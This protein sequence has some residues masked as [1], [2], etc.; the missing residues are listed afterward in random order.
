MNLQ[1]LN[2]QNSET[3]KLHRIKVNCPKLRGRGKEVSTDNKISKRN[4]NQSQGI[5]IIWILI[6][7]Q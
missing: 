2:W 3:E 7:R 5:D 4:M 6:M 1:R